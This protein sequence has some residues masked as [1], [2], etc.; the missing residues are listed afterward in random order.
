MSTRA[1]I[2][3]DTNVE[4]LSIKANLNIE[5]SINL[6]SGNERAKR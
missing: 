4:S 6:Q 3:C 1:L 2:N 5:W